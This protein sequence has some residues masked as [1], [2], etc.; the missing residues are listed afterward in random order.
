M[1]RPTTDA[2]APARPRFR[3]ALLSS[4]LVAS[5]GIVPISTARAQDGAAATTD[6]ATTAPV[7]I[8][9]FLNAADPD[10]QAFH[11]HVSI[12]SSPWMEGRLPGTKGMERARDYMEHWFRQA[13]LEP[14]FQPSEGGAKT[15]RQPF[16]LGGKRETVEERLAVRCADGVVEFTPGTDFQLTGFGRSGSAEGAVAFVGYGIEDGPDGYTSFA[17]DHSLEGKIALMLRFEPM[18]D[19]GNS[20]W[21][22][23]S[24]WSGRAGFQGKIAAVA[25]RN[26]AAIVIVNTPGANDPRTGSLGAGGGGRAMCDAPVFMMTAEAAERLVTRCGAG[27]GS[28]MDLR[29]SADRLPA[30]AAGSFD[31]E[32]VEAI[33]AGRTEERPVTAENVVGML[34]G[35]GDLAKEVVVIGGHLDHLGNG[36]FGSREGPGKL[37][38]GADDNA[39]GSAGVILLGDMLSKAYAAMPDDQPRRSVLFIGFDAEESGLNGSRH[40]VDNPIV[41]I[42]DTAMMMNFDMIGRILNGR[43]SVTTSGNAKGMT[44]WAQPFFEKS[45]LTVVHNA[46]RGGGGG[47]DH[48]SFQAVGVPIVFGI[49]ADFHDDY[50]TSRDTLDRIDRESAVDAI[51]LWRDLALDMAVRGERFEVDATQGPTRVG[52]MRVRAGLRTRG[53][54]DDSGI[55]VVD[56]SEGGS[57]ATAGIR[58]GDKLVKWNKKDIATREDFVADLREREPGD[59][60]QAVVIRDGQEVTVYV[61][62][63]GPPV[64][65]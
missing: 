31:L 39:S 4:A 62:L 65:P 18:D 12:L 16:A 47:S 63:Q 60:V 38:P 64:R 44:E 35:K 58:A 56:V 2:Q 10:V 27:G 49:I 41:P 24:G 3:S 45:G 19:E 26:P 30:G 14:A 20:R 37:H 21:S 36:D 48:A 22:N 33:A 17:A 52:S 1:L 55:E 59:K 57:A 53:T 50:H 6:G 11:E 23:G 5:V 43:L 28:L 15:Y 40:Y 9:E 61:E 8:H 13:G 54:D 29:V 51:R 46:A 7:K 34:P 32:G 42:R 25:K